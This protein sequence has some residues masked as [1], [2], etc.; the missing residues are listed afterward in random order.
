MAHAR[1]A[2]KGEGRAAVW[3]MAQGAI[4]LVAQELSLQAQLQAHHLP[5][6]WGSWSSRHGSP[7]PA[8]TPSAQLA[9][10]APGAPKPSADPYLSCCIKQQ[11][12]QVGTQKAGAGL[13]RFCSALLRSIFE[14]ESFPGG[15]WDVYFKK[16]HS[17]ASGGEH[18]AQHARHIGQEHSIA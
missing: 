12:V 2:C 17:C 1:P 15:C 6:L 4:T 11:T 10:L 5:H 18:P 14:A 9:Q 16:T 7:H 8:I 13:G 3:C